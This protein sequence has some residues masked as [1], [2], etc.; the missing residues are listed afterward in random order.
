MSLCEMMLNISDKYFFVMNSAFLVVSITL[1]AN[2]VRG[3]NL[4]TMV[5]AFLTTARGA[6]AIHVGQQAVYAITSRESALVK[7]V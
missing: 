7:L 1:A 5:T 6:T 2:V 3:V 4:V